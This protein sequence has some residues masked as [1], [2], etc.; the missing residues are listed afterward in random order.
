M[1]NAMTARIAWLANASWKNALISAIVIGP[2][3]SVWTGTKALL[4]KK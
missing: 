1:L 3:H 2:N 4:T